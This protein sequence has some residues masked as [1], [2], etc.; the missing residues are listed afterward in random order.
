MVEGAVHEDGD[1]RLCAALTKS[2]K[3][4][5]DPYG[6]RTMHHARL[7]PRAAKLGDGQQLD[8]GETH[9][10]DVVELANQR[11]E[12]SGFRPQLGVVTP[13]KVPTWSW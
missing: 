11:D 10:G 5:G 13:V 12:G 3:S 2:A 4:S 8:G 7:Y 1:A 6:P 9:L